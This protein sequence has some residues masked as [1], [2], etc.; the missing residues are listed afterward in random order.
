MPVI[1]VDAR[2]PSDIQEAVKFAGNRNLRLVIK[3]TGW[4]VSSVLSELGG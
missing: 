3:N 1:G 2:T 4:V